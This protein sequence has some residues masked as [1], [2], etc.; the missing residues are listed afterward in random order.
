MEQQV[1][2]RRLLAT[3]AAGAIDGL[4]GCADPDVAM[5]V[6]QVST[7]RAIA[8]RAPSQPGVRRG[9]RVAT[10]GSIGVRSL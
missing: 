2:R 10:S 7:D 1:S 6:E 4:A 3:C 5:F 9:V 8:E